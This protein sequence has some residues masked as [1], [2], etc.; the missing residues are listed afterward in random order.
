MTDL[1]IIGAGTAGLTA[2]IYGA[3]AGLSVKI[4]EK[5]FYGGQVISTS[6]IENYPGMPGVHGADFAMALHKQV[7]D[8][9]VAI[10]YET[11]ESVQLAGD[12]KRIVT[13]K[14]SH[15][16]KAIIIA[17]G[18]APRKL[19]VIGE[20]RW[21]GNG[22]A[23]CVTCDG[24]LYRGKDVAVIGGGNV[25]I[26]DALFLSE[27]CRNVTIIHRSANFKSEQRQLEQ[28]KA[29]DNVRIITDSVVKEFV[30]EN[31]LEKVR[32]ENKLTGQVTDIPVD[33]VFMAIGSEPDNSVFAGE[34]N[35]DK[36]G[37]VI[38]GED[39][40]TNVQGVFV[41]GDTRTKQVRQ[42]V[43]AAADGCVAALAA[44]DYLGG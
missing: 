34:I 32:L 1:V 44:K 28:V 26:K 29:K 20:D 2:A 39:C 12:I 19:E 33:G 11:V 42:L 35:L 27:I 17:T 9:D 38:A 24:M 14:G 40:H 36:A 21:I 7:K 15:Q 16:A 25:A 37:Y 23:F 10:L 8:L 13:S 18:A 22:I 31:M 3:R 4:I 6:S 5:A 43:T 30:G 41:A